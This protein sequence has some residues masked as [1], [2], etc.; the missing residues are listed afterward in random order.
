MVP[1]LDEINVYIDSMYFL[2]V[3]EETENHVKLGYEK[4]QRLE[5]WDP[6]GIKTWKK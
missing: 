4:G 6:P 2:A 5:L 3:N 1:W